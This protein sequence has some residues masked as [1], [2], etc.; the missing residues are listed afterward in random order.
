MAQFFNGDSFIFRLFPPPTQFNFFMTEVFSFFFIFFLV[1]PSNALPFTLPTSSLT[2]SCF[3]YF[4]IPYLISYLSFDILS[5]CHLS[6][7]ICHLPF[8]IFHLSS[9][10]AHCPSLISHLS[11][12]ISQLSTLISHLSSLI[13]HLSSLISHLSSLIS[14]LFI[15]VLSNHFPFLLLLIH[16]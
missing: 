11:S 10:I 7:V 2:H 5:F 1:C 12:P 9:L 16:P 15:L 8:V 14:S 3:S 13:S 6:F 4:F